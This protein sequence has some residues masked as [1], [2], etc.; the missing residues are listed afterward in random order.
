MESTRYTFPSPPMQYVVSVALP[1]IIYGLQVHLLCDSGGCTGMSLTSL[2]LKHDFPMKPTS[3]VGLPTEFV[4][5]PPPFPPRLMARGFLL[6][7][8]PLEGH[9]FH[10]LSDS[11]S[12]PSHLIF[13]MSA[14]AFVRLL[15]S[16]M[17]LAPL[18]HFPSRS[19]SRLR[20]FLL[21]HQARKSFSAARWGLASPPDIM[22]STHVFLP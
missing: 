4:F 13:E 9:H 18:H 22:L 5:F 8:L 6:P 10:H 17:T 1:T 7:H 16:G 15:P 11:P 3:C 21:P 19:L 12:Y 20:H 14:S 2:F